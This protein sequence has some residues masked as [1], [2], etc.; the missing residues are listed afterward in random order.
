MTTQQA[1]TTKGNTKPKR[2]FVPGRV[3]KATRSGV[4]ATVGLKSAGLEASK[5]ISKGYS[6]AKLHKLSKYTNLD[7]QELAVCI[8][9]KPATL[10]RRKSHGTFNVAESDRMYRFSSIVAAAEGLFEGDTFKAMAW[11]KKPRSAL[12]GNIPIDMSETSYDTQL[13]LDLIGKLEHG[14]LV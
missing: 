13:V 11:L 4:W 10:S 12:G 5:E 2:T 3:H 6:F 9:L 8:G 1:T 14:V 7:N